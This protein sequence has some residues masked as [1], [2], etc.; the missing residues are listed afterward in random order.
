[1]LLLDKLYLYASVSGERV[2]PADFRVYP[3]E[4]ANNNGTNNVF[5][6]RIRV[7]LAKQSSPSQLNSIGLAEYT[8][9]GRSGV[10]PAG[11]TGRPGKK[12][13][14]PFRSKNKSVPFQEF[15]SVPGTKSVPFHKFCSVPERPRK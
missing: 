2:Y 12:K 14:V 3:A 9:I 4:G 13:T 1:M 11:R 15:R 7:Y 6:E 8:L 5:V 10:S